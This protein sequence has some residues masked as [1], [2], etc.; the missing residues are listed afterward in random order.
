[1]N[2][3]L[4]GDD[5]PT[6]QSILVANKIEAHNSVIWKPSLELGNGHS[7]TIIA[8]NSG[9]VS[10]DNSG[11]FTVFG[12]ALLRGLHDATYGPEKESLT[13]KSLLHVRTKWAKPQFDQPVIGPYVIFDQ[14]G[15]K[16]AEGGFN[17]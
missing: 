14:N 16:R 15:Y 5:H 7:L 3:L 10:A 11:S 6:I 13:N 8:Y 1:L 12:S 4:E 17:G 9:E 2:A